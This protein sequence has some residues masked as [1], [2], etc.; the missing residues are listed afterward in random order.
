[1]P[2][3]SATMFDRHVAYELHEFAESYWRMRAGNTN[4]ADLNMNHDVFCTHGRNLVEFFSKRPDGHHVVAADFATAAY[5][6]WNIQ[7]GSTAHDARGRLNN[8]VSHLT[9]NRPENQTDQM[10]QAYRDKVWNLISDEV[11]RWLPHIRSEFD[12]S[13]L[14]LARYD[15]QPPGPLTLELPQTNQTALQATN[16][17]TSVSSKSPQ[18]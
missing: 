14:P 5:V 17:F 16:I 12:K 13:K 6:P 8:E 1:M 9:W 4:Q 11:R 2:T 15:Q 7:H 3:N 18:S 10:D